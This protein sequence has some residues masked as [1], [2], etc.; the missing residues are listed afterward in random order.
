[1]VTEA[2]YRPPMTRLAP[3]P[4]P[5]DA[6]STH[7][8]LAGFEAACHGEAPSTLLRRFGL[9]ELRHRPLHALSTG[10]GRKLLLLECL[11][12][13]PPLLILD[14]ALDG[15]DAYSMADLRALLQ[16]LYSTAGQGGAGGAE[17]ALVVV[18]H[19]QE[20][21]LPLPSHAL[22]LGQGSEGS[23]YHAGDWGSMAGKV[24]EFFDSTPS[25]SSASTTAAPIPAA[26]TTTITTTS[27]TPSEGEP[28]IDFRG[29]T[30]QYGRTVVLDQLKWLV[31]EGEKWMVQG[32]NGTGKSTVLQLITG[33]N[34]QG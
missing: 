20:D 28:L 21:L 33:D 18:S 1:M 27:L 26:T 9:W 15:L 14:E 13:R 24:G 7:A 3:L 29:V 11:L 5:Y 6:G 8:L 31:R 10:E 4:A 34:L 19:H 17:Q 32:G 2:G 30:V 23:G 25:S 12:S 22:L 16:D